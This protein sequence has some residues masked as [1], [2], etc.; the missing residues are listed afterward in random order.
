ML[1]YFNCAVTVCVLCLFLAVPSV[2]LKSVIVAF[3]GHIH[4]LWFSPAR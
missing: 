2:G 1:L 3:P 4:F